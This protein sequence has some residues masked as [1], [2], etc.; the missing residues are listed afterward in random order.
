MWWTLDIKRYGGDLRVWLGEERVTVDRIWLVN[1]QGWTVENMELSLMRTLVGVICGWSLIKS[2]ESL[3]V[4]KR[5]AGK[6]YVEVKIFGLVCNDTNEVHWVISVGWNVW[7]VVRVD[8][9]VP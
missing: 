3:L 9:C 8:K 2:V 1:R 6:R 5:G 4:S 7:L